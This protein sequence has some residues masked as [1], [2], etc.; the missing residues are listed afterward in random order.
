MRFPKVPIRCTANANPQNIVSHYM[1]KGKRRTAS[2]GAA[3]DPERNGKSALLVL[4]QEL[5]Q[6]FDHPLVPVIIT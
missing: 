3:A 4:S 2:P 1:L 6:N 5:S